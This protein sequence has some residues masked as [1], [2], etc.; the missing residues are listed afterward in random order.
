[1][2]VVGLKNSAPSRRSESFFFTACISSSFSKSERL[3]LSIL[4][5]P[6]PPTTCRKPFLARFSQKGRASGI[7][8]RTSILLIPLCR[9]NPSTAFS[10]S[11]L[12]PCF[13]A[14]GETSM[15]FKRSTF[16]R[17]PKVQW[18]RTRSPNFRGFL[19]SI[20]STCIRSTP[21]FRLSLILMTWGPFFR[22]CKI[23][24]SIMYYRMKPSRIR[25]YAALQGI[26]GP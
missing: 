19:G 7:T 8:T 10:N 16:P 4:L 14:C 26:R 5:T 17:T 18:P 12:C 1:M 9:A 3:D 6:A 20:S 25:K 21:D 11:M 22:S 15:S 2:F 23:L 24:R 13:R